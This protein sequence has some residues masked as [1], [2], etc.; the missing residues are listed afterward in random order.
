MSKADIDSI[1]NYIINHIQWRQTGGIV[2][3]FDKTNWPTESA[4]YV[5]TVRNGS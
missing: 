4:I 1:E 2:V 5:V 3:V